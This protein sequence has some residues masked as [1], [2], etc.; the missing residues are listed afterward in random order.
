MAM[1]RLQDAWP[2]KIGFY[3][4]LISEGLDDLTKP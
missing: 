3:K 1:Q 4:I 2:S